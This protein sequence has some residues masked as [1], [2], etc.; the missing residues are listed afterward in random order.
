MIGAAPEDVYKVVG[1]IH[2]PALPGS[3][4]G[5]SCSTLNV[6]LDG[7]RRDAEAYAEGGADA[8]IVENFGDLPFVKDSVSP[9]TI[10]AMT[11]AL[12]AVRDVSALPVGVNV[13]RNDVM[14]AVSIAAM[15]GGSFVRANVYVGAAVTDQGLIE[16]RAAEVQTLISSLDAPVSVWADVDVKHAAPVASR[17]LEEVAEDAV[18]RGLARAVIVTG[19]ATG[20]PASRTDLEKVRASLPDTPVYAGSGITTDSISSVL[21][22]VD[23]V[24]VGTGA[25]HDGIVT[26]AVDVARVRALVQAAG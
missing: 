25:K 20:S 3:P 5:G 26:N 22:V 21:S 13:L 9:V 1:V 4:R 24:I 19:K 23:G 17:P 10:A 18:V 2:L 8:V 16:G 11:R 12:I 6:I 14:S 15:V 7:V